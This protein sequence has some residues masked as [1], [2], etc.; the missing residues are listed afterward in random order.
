MKKTMMALALCLMSALTFA[1][2]RQ[3]TSALPASTPAVSLTIDGTKHV[4]K[5]DKAT[6]QEVGDSQVRCIVYAGKDK[7]EVKLPIAYDTILELGAKVAELCHTMG[8]ASD[9]QYAD[10]Q[11]W[12]RQQ[13]GQ[14]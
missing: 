9:E 7:A 8:I 3:I 10:F 1:A 12:Y 13:T 4:V 11:K 14:K 6:M 2:G 5:P